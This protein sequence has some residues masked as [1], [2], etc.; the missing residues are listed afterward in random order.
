[1]LTEGASFFFEDS[2]K[3]STC[4]N[5]GSLCSVGRP[6]LFQVDPYMSSNTG[7]LFCG[8]LFIALVVATY[9]YYPKTGLGGFFPIHRVFHL[10]YPGTKANVGDR[11]PRPGTRGLGSPDNV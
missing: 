5:D 3:F 2:F 8:M 1:M 6:S 11:R 9:W 10:F 7:A 4:L